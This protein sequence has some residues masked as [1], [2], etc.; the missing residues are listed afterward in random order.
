[1]SAPFLSTIDW[2]RPWLAPFRGAAEPLLDAAD[3]R[4]ALNATAQRMGLS[5]H[6]DLPLHFVPQADLPQGIPYEAF[7][8]ETGWVPTRDNLHDFFNALVWLTFPQIKRQLNALQAAEIAKAVHQDGVSGHMAVRGKLRD[9]ATIFDENAALLVTSDESWLD[10]L[11]EHC[12]HQALFER[13]AVLGSAADVL[14]FG[15]AL[16][17]KLVSPYKAITA[18]AW[19]MRVD[20]QF[21]A[22]PVQ[23]RLAWL[24][25]AIARKLERGLGTPDFT[26]LPVLGVPGWWS[27]QDEQFYADVTVFR[28]KR[29]NQRV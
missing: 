29:T 6:R 3:W 9:A 18:H 26:P 28:P 21:F 14:L 27:G 5:N 24:D 20:A 4:Q 19:N 1:M 22:L 13:R 8:S 16:M 15:H 10:C 7:I 2:S 17:E 12:W 23:G 25:S 11:R